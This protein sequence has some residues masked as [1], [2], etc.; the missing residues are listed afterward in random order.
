MSRRGE[1]GMA[2]VGVLVVLAFLGALAAALVLAATTEMGIAANYREATE[3]L[4]AAEAGVAFVMQEVAAIETWDEVAS[5]GG[6][7][8]FVDGPVEG[9]RSIGVVALDLAVATEALNSTMPAGPGGDPAWVP[10]AFG[11]LQ[12]L[13]P[14][15]AGQSPLYVVVWVANHATSSDPSMRGA[16]SI[17][18]QAYGPRGSRRA[19]EVIVEKADTF[20]VRR[21]S[22]RQWP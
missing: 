7:S 15:G 14:P 18:G 8:T 9:I 11:R 21:R 5:T 13:T 16:L 19:V 1:R 2:L 6:E 12:D 22:W 17:L 4:Y 10:Y 20:S 3:T